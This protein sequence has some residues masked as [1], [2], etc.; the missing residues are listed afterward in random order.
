MS[1]ISAISNDDGIILP[2]NIS[3][4]IGPN[5]PNGVFGMP[6]VKYSIIGRVDNN[7][8]PSVSSKEDA[9]NLFNASIKN[10]LQ[11]ASQVG[12]NMRPRVI[13][14]EEGKFSVVCSMAIFNKSFSNPN[15]AA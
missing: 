7:P 11:N 2:D 15:K 13:T 5:S 6:Y 3:Y 9:I 1:E 12:W 10:V 14:N 8:I 4:F